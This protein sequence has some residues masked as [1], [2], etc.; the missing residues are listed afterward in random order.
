MTDPG[1]GGPHTPPVDAPVTVRIDGQ[2]VLVSTDDGTRWSAPGAASALRTELGRMA[3]PAPEAT[4]TAAA[5]ATLA[6]AR[7][8]RPRSRP[9]ASG[10]QASELP[11]GS[12][13]RLSDEEASG[14]LRDV[15]ASRRSRRRL[16]GTL[17]LRLLGA[18][19]VR[20]L[21]TQGFDA[22]T[23]PAR[24][25]H[26][27]PSAGGLRPV[28]VGVLASAVDGLPSRSF[29]GFDP[30]LCLLREVALPAHARDRLVAA[31]VGAGDLPQAPPALLVLAAD[32]GRTAARYPG[33]SSLTWRDSGVVLAGLALAA[34]DLS[35]SACILGT[36]GSLPAP[37]A[38]RLL[39]AC[40]VT[41]I[42]P[43]Q[44]VGMIALGPAP[45]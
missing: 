8:L 15:F 34:E 14:P 32:F 30:N 25:F 16:Q 4:L 3:V 7:R 36:S 26:P 6:E 29:W 12:T 40:G 22:T 37:I 44:D 20:V 21:A 31:A 9:G 11:A 24:S 28:R 43:V 27:L 5:V 23:T 17:P 39:A 19:F 1:T 10:A 18:L 38:D 41:P 35:L 13:I 33:G 2:D 45:A 42:G